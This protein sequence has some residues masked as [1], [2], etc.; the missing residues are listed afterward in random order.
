MG[1]TPQGNSFKGR[2]DAFFSALDICLPTCPALMSL[3]GQSCPW[4]GFS[5]LFPGTLRASHPHAAF[6]GLLILPEPV[7][8]W[9]VV[10]DQFLSSV[11][12]ATVA[13]CAGH[14]SQ[15]KGWYTALL[16]R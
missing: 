1:R 12:P 10:Q 5:W 4:L 8:A 9:A 2:V 13:G 7:T 6:P 11:C 3:H 16:P 14:C 15:S